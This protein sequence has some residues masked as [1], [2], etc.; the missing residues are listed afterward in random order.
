MMIFRMLL[1]MPS[2]SEQIS[3]SN[4]NRMLETRTTACSCCGSS[5]FHEIA[6]GRDYIYDGS[7]VYLSLVACDA[8]AHIYL[9]PQPTI[10]AL[11]IMYPDNYG[12][13]SSKFRSGAN[14]LAAIK[15]AV[16]L[17]R[18]KQVAGVLV[19]GMRILDVGCGNG[20]LLH[21]LAKIRPDLEL[22]GL[23]WHFPSATREELEAAGVHLIEGTLEN[24][25][26]PENFFDRVLMY[27]LVEHLWEP[28]AGLGKLAAALKPGGTIA[29]E[30][31][32]TDGYD[33]YFF[34]A[35]TWGG[36]YVPRHLNLYN[37]T[38][39]ARLLAE[40]GLE[41]VQ[42]KSLPAPVIWC[43]SLQASLQERFGAKTKIARLF[44][45]RNIAALAGFALLDIA[46]IGVGFKSSNQ[47]TIARKPASG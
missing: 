42:Q 7:D 35:G 23:D 14:P 47:Q 16:N 19:K 1:K 31:P 41:I 33:R 44:D 34:S 39:L 3:P 13:F 40:T 28:R 26:L 30:T 24:V 12:T 8:C 37:F 17:R 46:A 2:S 25:P 38:R 45:L 9:N 36:Y 4:F 6:R 5:A 21:T 22:Y 29:I 43:Y 15:N 18:F 10:N 20:Q 11:P 32:D 27:Q